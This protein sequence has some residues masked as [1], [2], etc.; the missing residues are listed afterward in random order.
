MRSR[1]LWFALATAC[2]FGTLRCSL[3]NLGYLR[4]DLCA[5]NCGRL[6][7][8]P[9]TALGDPGFDSPSGDADAALVA[10]ASLDADAS[11]A[12]DARREASPDPGIFCEDE[13]PTLHCDPR[14]S[15]C[16]RGADRGKH[17]YCSLPDGGCLEQGVDSRYCDDTA[18]C[19]AA[20]RP[21][22]CCKVDFASN[23]CLSLADCQRAANEGVLCDPQA[24]E[25]CPNGALCRA[26]D[27]SGEYKCVGL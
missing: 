12:A 14:I 3:A 10:D 5:P 25:S 8:G 22:V 4:D 18:D 17:D 21:G 20:G 26:P 24:L 9:D 11:Q 23:V 15:Y 6:E 13:L 1:V 27:A 7:A 19:E 2:F 16:C